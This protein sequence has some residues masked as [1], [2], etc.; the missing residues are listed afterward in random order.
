MMTPDRES[1][2]GVVSRPGSLNDNLGVRVHDEHLGFVC[3]MGGPGAGGDAAGDLVQDINGA[4]RN[5]RGHGGPT[6]HRR[7]HGAWRPSRQ[8]PVDYISGWDR[9]DRPHVPRRGGTRS[10][11]FQDEMARSVGHRTSGFF[12]PVSRLHGDRAL[13][14]ALGRHGQ[15]AV[16]RRALDDLGGRRV[17]GDAGAWLQCHRVW[18]V[19]P[20]R[21]FHQ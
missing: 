5:C 8:H 4:F 17:C 2:R 3:S 7:V 9:R 1:C 15:L 16:R 21:V 11:H 20:S 6:G 14:A 10:R 12:R 18:Q 13:C 19:D